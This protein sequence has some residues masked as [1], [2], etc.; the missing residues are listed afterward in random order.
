MIDLLIREGA[1]ADGTGAA[2][3]AADVVVRA[4]RVEAVEA[5]GSVDPRAAGRVIEAGGL[6]VTPGFVDVHTHYDG[7]A[8]WDPVLGPSSWHGVTS[9][10]MGNCGVGFAPA[11]PEKRRWLIEL[12]EG[13]EDIP[14]S[15]LSEGIRWSWESFPEYLD[16]LE[17]LPRSVEIAAQVPHG[18]VRAYV[19]GERGG[20]NEPAKADDV[21]RMADIVREGVAAGA[22]AFSSNRLPLHTSIHGDPVPGTFAN[23]EELGALC[24]AVREGGGQVVEVVPAG[25]M[26][27]DPAAPLREVALYR[28]LSLDTGCT[29]T[30]S[31]AQIN[32]DP[33]HWV[34]ILEA[35][36]KANA[37]GARL[38]PQ[39]SGRPAGLL[40]S[41][42][43]FNPF[44]ERP[45]YQ[46]LLGLAPPERLRR[47]RD[48]ATRRAILAEREHD[49]VAMKMMMNSLDTTF[50]LE[51]GPA[52]EPDPEE[53]IAAQVARRGAD[54]HEVLYDTMCELADDAGG[55][56]G[57]LHVFFSGYKGGSLADIGEMMRHPATVVGLADGGAHCSMIC[58]ASMPTFLLQHWVR[59]RTRGPRLS[60]E[61][62]VRMLSREPAELYGLADRGTL[63]PG[64]RADLNV[65]DLEALTLRVPEIAR[66]LPTGAARVVQRADGYR[67]TVVAGEVTFDAGADTG[68]RPGG[69]IRRA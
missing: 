41:W 59:D 9:L 7:Q 25:A 62:G 34:G 42:E 12:M 58:D 14:G 64:R 38:V 40:L 22:V 23:E 28:A 49:G 3:R 67:A 13:V 32:T 26:G 10:V 68:A 66:D 56:S 24:R 8:T 50:A 37:E 15:A 6:W 30:F 29:I 65:I 46:A 20:R 57:F 5:A 2:T 18:A 48:P 19:M 33:K 36:E 53:S 4:G 45:S 54:A 21:A 51:G 31:L 69:L 52:F 17:S 1:L 43:T 55:Q 27:E 61:E 44:M 47:L 35:T 39:V 16:A 60:I 11:R 63:E